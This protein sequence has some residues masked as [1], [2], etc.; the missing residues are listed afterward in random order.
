MPTYVVECYWPRITEQQANQAL[1]GIAGAHGH[2][3]PS[4]QLRPLACILMPSDGLAIFLVS[5]PSAANV[6]EA[7]ELI[8]LPFDRI[9]ESLTIMPTGT[10]D[11]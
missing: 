10:S 2:A 9:V 3:A 6:R 8:Q 4:N 11:G 1:A 7:G 5:S